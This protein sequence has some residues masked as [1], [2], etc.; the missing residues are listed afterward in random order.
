MFSAGRSSRH[1]HGLA[2]RESCSECT[3]AIWKGDVVIGISVLDATSEIRLC[4]RVVADL[5]FRIEI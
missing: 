4:G 2:F 1:P 5:Y 3:E